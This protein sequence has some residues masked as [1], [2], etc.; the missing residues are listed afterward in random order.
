[1]TSSIEP[2]L[3]CLGQMQQRLQ[4]LRQQP[5]QAG[6]FSQWALA[7]SD[8]LGALPAQF[9][10]VLRDLLNRLEASA[11]FAEDSCSFSQGELYQSLQLWLDKAGERLQAHH[12][13][14]L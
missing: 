5:Q 13:A 4:Q 8:L 12:R 2:A 11:M 6:D 14:G 3:Q 9:G 10:A 1:M 7:Q